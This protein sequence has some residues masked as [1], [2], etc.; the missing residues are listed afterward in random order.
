MLY[1]V[2]T[3]RNDQNRQ[4]ISKR[5]IDRHKQAVHDK[6]DQPDNKVN[7]IKAFGGAVFSL[8][9]KYNP[10]FLKQSNKKRKKPMRF[11]RTKPIVSLPTVALPTSGV[12]V[13]VRSL[14]L[15][16]PHKL[17]CFIFYRNNFV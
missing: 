6:P 1:E 4:R 15:S 14:P 3:R 16:L 13:E 12:R 5:R 2:I 8:V 11:L 9:P 10:F 17:P 7:H